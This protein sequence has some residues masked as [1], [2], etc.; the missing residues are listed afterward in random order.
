MPDSREPTLGDAIPEV[1]ARVR[2]L[3]EWMPPCAKT[4]SG[5]LRRVAVEKALENLEA[6]WALA[7]L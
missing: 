2:K 3:L 7:R 6:A 5:H 4:S 1:I